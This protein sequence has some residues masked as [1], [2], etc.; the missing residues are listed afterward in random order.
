MKS[1]NAPD[2]VAI[3]SGPNDTPGS[4][5]ADKQ[6]L[7]FLRTDTEGRTDIWVVS[8][9]QPDN[10]RPLLATGFNESYPEFS[11]NGRWLAYCS[12]ANDPA[13]PPE[14]F[15]RPYPGPGDPIQ[16]S[17]A[18]GSEP[19]WSRDGNEIFFRSG[20]RMFSVRVK[21]SET[22]IVPDKPVQ[23]FERPFGNAAGSR[24]YDVARDGRFLIRQTVVENIEARQKKVFPS[25]LRV[26]LNWADE[27]RRNVGK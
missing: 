14:V 6:E 27:L 13:R 19:A 24:S 3:T 26:I 20:Q 8:V 17:N 21:V 4:W 2:A 5:K 16:I 10:A 25:T 22:Q 18:G 1:V 11:P 9:D 23:L 12:N 7:A 15:V